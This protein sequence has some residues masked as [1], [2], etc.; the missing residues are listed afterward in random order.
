MKTNRTMT[1]T[2]FG[3]ADR[4]ARDESGV[5]T[6]FACFMIMMMVLVGGIGVDL[7]HAEMERTRLQNTLDRAVLAAADLDQSLKPSDVV[8]DYF[9]KSGMEDNLISVTVSQGLNYRTVTAAAEAVTET[10]FMHLMGVEELSAPGRSA[11]EERISK[12]EVSLVVDVSGSME[13]NSKMTNLIDAANTFTTSLLK[14]ESADL[15]SISLVPYSEHVNISP[16]IFN[17]L[18]TNHR[19]D[20]SHCVEIPDYEFDNAELDTSL[21]YDQAQHYQWNYSSSDGNVVDDTVCPHEDYESILPLS[22]SLS[23]LQ[24]NINQFTPRAGTSIFMAVK[25][26]AALLD[27]STRG[28]VTSLIGSGQIDNAFSGRPADYSDDETLKTMIVMTDGKNDRSNRIVSAA[29]GNNSHYVHW[30]NYNFWWYLNKYVSSKYHK[31]YYFQKY[32][33]DKGDELTEAICTAAKDKGIIIWGVGFE[34]DSHGESVLK[35]CASSPSHYFGV[36]G[37]EIS[38]A[39]SAIASQINQLRLT[40]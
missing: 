5:A 17:L 2:M 11:A 12:V 25:W 10:Q 34:V 9:E 14:P 37:V 3:A 13:W 6:I 20:F 39:F 40:Q 30:S 31:N 19:H 33:A 18:N 21:T 27:P 38:E 24:G 28:I 4:F 16:A 26:G 23:D 35:A 32:D 22:Q 36:E 8:T 7:M 15:I 1:R 29:Y